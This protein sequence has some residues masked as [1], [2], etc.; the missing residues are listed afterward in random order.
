MQLIIIIHHQKH[1]V[2]YIVGLMHIAPHNLGRVVTRKPA[3]FA[4]LVVCGV[5]HNNAPCGAKLTHVKIH[6]I[7]P[8]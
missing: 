1:S 5:M 2:N 6:T 3:H 8:V 4:L 7:I